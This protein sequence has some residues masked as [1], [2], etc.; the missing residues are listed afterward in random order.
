MQ[1]SHRYEYTPSS[2]SSLAGSG[3]CYPPS[4]TPDVDFTAFIPHSYDPAPNP[5][6]DASP[7]GQSHGSASAQEYFYVPSEFDPSLY[8]KHH[9]PPLSFN[10]L[11]NHTP[12]QMSPSI[13]EFP[14]G[15]SPSSSSSSSSSSSPGST[16]K[17]EHCGTT[18]TPLWRRDPTTQLPLCNACGLYIQQRQMQRPQALIDAE[19]APASSASGSGSG[20]GSG[21]L[22]CSHCHTHETS[23]WRRSKEGKQVCNACGVYERAKGVKR[24]LSLR[25]DLVR[26]RGRYPQN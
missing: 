12:S 7:R 25:S 15:A 20:G 10:D 18:R 8:G 14:A 5:L 16:K 23:V 13:P 1:G 24:P 21:I 22:E 3:M 9:A 4:S 2:Y 26:P 17:C 19:A 6:Y 11:R